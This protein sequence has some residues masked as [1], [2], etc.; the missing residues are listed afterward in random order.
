MLVQTFGRNSTADT[1]GFS[2]KLPAVARREIAD[3]N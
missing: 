3:E 2:G 1:I